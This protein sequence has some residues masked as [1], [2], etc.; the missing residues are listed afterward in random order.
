M[1]DPKRPFTIDI[2]V[3]HFSKSYT[4]IETNAPVE[5]DYGWNFHLT[6]P[7]RPDKDGARF[8]AVDSERLD[9]QLGRNASGLFQSEVVEFSE[10]KLQWAAEK[11][12][13]RIYQRD[14]SRY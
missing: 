6:G 3:G 2:K 7:E 12:V 10:G 11:I 9:Y 13:D 4:V 1:T 5:Y 8:V 14:I